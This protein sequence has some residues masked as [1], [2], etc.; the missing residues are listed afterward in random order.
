MPFVVA[1][2]GSGIGAY[3]CRYQ[4]A[5]DGHQLRLDPAW[6]LPSTI[7][8]DGRVHRLPAYSVDLPAHTYGRN[9]KLSHTTKGSKSA[10]MPMSKSRLKTGGKFTNPFLEKKGF[11]SSWMPL[12]R[13]PRLVDPAR[14][15]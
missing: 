15:R 10:S 14:L 3:V 13:A 1:T 11:I 6:A 9:Q 8:G 7:G 2:L 4:S 12:R 5:L